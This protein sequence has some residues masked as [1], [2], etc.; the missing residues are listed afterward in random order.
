VNDR[1]GA[2][3]SVVDADLLGRE[4]VLHQL[5]LDAFIGE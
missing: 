5:V 1:E 4:L 3:I 2:G